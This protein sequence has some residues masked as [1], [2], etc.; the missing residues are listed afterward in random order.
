MK[1]MK[2]GLK[3]IARAWRRTRKWVRGHLGLLFAIATLLLITI[4]HFYFALFVPPTKEKVWKEVQVVE[5]MSFKAIARTLKNEGIIR[6]RT[7]FEILG[8][9]QGISRKT[10]MGFYGF[11]T[12]MSMWEVLE[13]LRKGRI[14]EYEIVVPE[15]Y[16]LYQI[17]WTLTGTPLLSEAQEFIEL[18]K[19]R[20]YVRSLGIESDTL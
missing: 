14:I 19:N 15:G 4:V 11:N 9:I 13:T 6:Y 12:N 18:V 17:G 20:E 7:Y 10:R 5:G 2:K 8:R 3:P 16:N 1:V